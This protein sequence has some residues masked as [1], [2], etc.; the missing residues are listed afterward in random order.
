VQRRLGDHGKVIYEGSPHSGSSLEFYLDR[1]PLYVVA[2]RAASGRRS[3]TAEEAVEESGARHPV[4]LI[5][6][7]ERAP[8]WQERLTTRYHI[9]HQVSTCGRYIVATNQP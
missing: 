3:I 7:K 8:F 4:Y 9:Y 6:E 2:D 5:C 1:Q